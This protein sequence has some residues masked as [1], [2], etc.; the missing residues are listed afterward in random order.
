MI[1][2]GSQFKGIEGP[3][4]GKLFT[5]KKVTQN[6]VEYESYSG[7]LYSE[8]RKLFE[9]RLQRINE[10]WKNSKNSYKSRKEELRE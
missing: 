5:V 7:T 6:C 3:G 10:Y 8:S 9:K 2:K 1:R 4:K